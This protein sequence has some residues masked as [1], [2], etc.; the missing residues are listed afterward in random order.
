MNSAT[1]A[2]KERLYQMFDGPDESMPPRDAFS[3]RASRSIDGLVRSN[4]DATAQSID[5]AHE[6]GSTTS[7][8]FRDVPNRRSP[9]IHSQPEST[10]DLTVGQLPTASTDG[11]LVPSRGRAES[12]VKRSIDKGHVCSD[13][14][15]SSLSKTF[16]RTIPPLKSLEQKSVAHSRVNMTINLPSP[17]YVGGGTIEGS[18]SISIEQPEH[19]MKEKPLYISKLS[20]DIMGLEEVSDGR[21]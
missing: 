2:I 1:E 9:R 21:K 6:Q 7:L 20:I 13:D 8:P 19:K 10:L 14:F 5:L 3:K 18:L 15:R 17:L 12:P 16:I 11:L 4:L